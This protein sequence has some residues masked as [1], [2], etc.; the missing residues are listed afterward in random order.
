[1]SLYVGQGIWYT[2][3]IWL[4]HA[5]IRMHRMTQISFPVICVTWKDELAGFYSKRSEIY[6]NA[7]I[8]VD[9]AK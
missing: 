4:N 8:V 1:M 6:V 2:G 7:S 9:D 3:T 5:V